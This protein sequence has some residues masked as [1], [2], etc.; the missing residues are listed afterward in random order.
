MFDW[1]DR[2]RKEFQGISLELAADQLKKLHWGFLKVAHVVPKSMGGAMMPD[3][4]RALCP[5][6]HRVVDRLPG[7]L[8]NQLRH[9]I[10]SFKHSK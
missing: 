7:D 2:V 9:L 5:T 4:V 8:K 3:N 10:P 1:I 6:C